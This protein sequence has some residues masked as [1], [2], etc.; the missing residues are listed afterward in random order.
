MPAHHTMLRASRLL[1][2][3]MRRAPFVQCRM[4]STSQPPDAPKTEAP[5]SN[6]HVGP[7]I[8]CQRRLL[9]QL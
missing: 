9:V 6:P 2:P 7:Y 3:A 8:A 4:Q 5:K 1:S